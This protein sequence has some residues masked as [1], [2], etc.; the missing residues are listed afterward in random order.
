VKNRGLIAEIEHPTSGR[1]KQIAPTVKLSATP[2][3]M[4][5]PPPL[6]GEHTSEVMK[7]LGYSDDTIN[8]LSRGGVVGKM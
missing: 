2:G 4:R 1:I 8:R 5:S 3:E 6:L 7:E